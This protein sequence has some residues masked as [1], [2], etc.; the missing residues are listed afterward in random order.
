MDQERGE[1][2]FV[3]CDAG[4]VVVLDLET[5]NEIAKIPIGGEP[6]VIWH[7]A[8]RELLYCAIGKP[9]LLQVIDES[10]NDIQELQT[11]DGAHTFAFDKLRQRLYSFQ[12]RI[13]SAVVYAESD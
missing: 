4:I 1:R 2:A 5:G 13:C 7:N 6:D 8:K 9:G 12:P 11:E 10:M 3:A